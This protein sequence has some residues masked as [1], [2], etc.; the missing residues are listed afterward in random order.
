MLT[1]SKPLSAHLAFNK[2]PPPVLIEQITA[3]DLKVHHAR[4]PRLAQPDSHAVHCALHSG[5]A[6]E[7]AK[8][9]LHN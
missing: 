4:N 5:T 3:D 2:L 1:I 6:A 7:G 9:T 8:S